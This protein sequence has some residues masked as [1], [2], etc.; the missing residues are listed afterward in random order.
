MSRI[1][2]VSNKDASFI[3]RIAFWLTKRK[4]GKVLTPV[5][6]AA[7]RPRILRAVGSM[8]GAQ[9]RL[10]HIEPSLKMLLYTF[11]A[12]KVGCPF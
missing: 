2:G 5:R 9:D 11:V 6:I 7:H 3:A 12:T 10:K 4:W 1:Q 8:E